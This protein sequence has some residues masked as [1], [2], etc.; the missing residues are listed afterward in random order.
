MLKNLIVTLISDDKPGIVE[1]VASVITQ[2]HGNW[3]ES[4]LAKLAGKFAGVVRIQVDAS[5]EAA[6]AA[7]LNEM[8]NQRMTVLVDE[9]N[10]TTASADTNQ[11][12]HFHAT[13][14]DRPGIVKEISSA[15]AL[16]QINLEKLDTR[17]SSMPYSGDPLFE[18][19]GIMAV[20]T[21]LN[22][23]DLTEKL[24]DIADELAMDI[25]LEETR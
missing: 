1:S 10:E 13:G 2:H 18:A 23:S 3:L 25:V 14:P 11:T 6:L 22:R 4:Q 21:S 24:D 8:S 16:Y 15:L 12:L 9:C 19:E 20:P 7:A 5:N 17:L